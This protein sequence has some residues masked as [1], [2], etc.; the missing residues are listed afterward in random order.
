MA[1]SDRVIEKIVFWPSMEV[2]ILDKESINA[3]CLGLSRT[4]NQVNFDANILDKFLVAGSWLYDDYMKISNVSFLRLHVRERSGLFPPVQA[5]TAHQN[6]MAAS[7][8]HIPKTSWRRMQTDSYLMM[9]SL[10]TQI[11]CTLIRWTGRKPI[12]PYPAT[13]RNWIYGKECFA[14]CF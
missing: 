14:P 6:K 12:L 11:G 10:R 7:S 1:N 9:D 8:D 2:I 4:R 3:P 5:V 13:E